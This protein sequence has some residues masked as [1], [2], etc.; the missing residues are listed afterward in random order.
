VRS[1]LLHSTRIIEASRICSD[2]SQIESEAPAVCY[3]CA[4]LPIDGWE[5]DGLW[6]DYNES[7]HMASESTGSH[8]KSGVNR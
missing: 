3:K 5:M 4:G 7:L 6:M 2:S 1:R 8:G